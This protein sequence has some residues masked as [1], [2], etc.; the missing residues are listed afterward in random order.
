MNLL[1]DSCVFIW[2]STSPGDLSAA[3]NIAI[4]DSRN[5]LWLSHASVWE[6]QLKHLAGKLVLPE[7]PRLWFSRQMAVWNV[8]DWPLDMESLYLT[9][10]LPPIHKD[11]FDRMLAA[12]SITHALTLVSP[13]AVFARY[14]VTV[15]W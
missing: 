14:G 9:S 11:P 12:Q 2:L 10:D 5:E 8:K 7:K 3:A 13:D 15:L 1:L 6:I 4:N